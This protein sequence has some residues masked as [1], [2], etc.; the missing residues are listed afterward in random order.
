MIESRTDWGRLASF[1]EVLAVASFVTLDYAKMWLGIKSS[2][3]DLRLQ[4]FLDAASQ[5]VSD[6]CRR[7]F[8][9]Q[10]YTD[11]YVGGTNTST[12]ALPHSPITAVASIHL[13]NLGRFG[14]LAGA[15]PAA[16]LLTVG[17]DYMLPFDGFLGDDCDDSNDT[18]PCVKSGLIRRVDS[19]WPGETQYDGGLSSRQGPGAGNIK[20]TYT[21]GWT[22][23][24]MPSVI[25]AAVCQIAGVIKRSAPFGGL[26]GSE[27]WQ[28]YSYSLQN[29][30]AL[31]KYPELGSTRSFL[32][33]YRRT[34]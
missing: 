19:V 20:I 8:L 29:P 1:L 31:A 13:D 28:G 5:N 7:R 25:R 32:V 34:L 14:Q 9:Q 33:K 3:D 26:L 2:A 15:F 22:Q 4:A 30:Q 10:T 23:D 24:T 11:V 27:S 16:T 17:V 18:T 12:F 21:A 6:Y